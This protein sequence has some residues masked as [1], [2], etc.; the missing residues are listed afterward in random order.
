MAR[1]VSL[2]VADRSKFL[3]NHGAKR[4]KCNVLI[5]GHRVSGA[6]KPYTVNNLFNSD[7]SDNSG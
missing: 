4:Q 1:A 2:N 6:I 5:C 3:K 7:Q